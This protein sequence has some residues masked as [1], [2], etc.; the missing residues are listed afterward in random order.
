MTGDDR[1]RWALILGASSGMGEASS[2]ALAAAGYHICGVHLDLRSRRGHVD[3]V[4]SGIRALGREAIFLNLNAADDAQR[5]AAI[6]T[7]SRRFAE[8][9]DSGARPY[10]RVVLHSLAFGSLAPYLADDGQPA[11]DRRRMEM[12]ADVMAHSLVY[13][14]Q[15]L[16]AAGL[17]ESGS[18]IL[19]M[20]SEGSSIAVP[21]YGAVSAAKAALESHVRQL[22]LE[23]GRRGTGITV[24]AIQAGVTMTPALMKV[25]VHDE[26]IE[27]SRRRNPSGRMTTTSDVARA[28]VGL[29]G[30]AFGF[31][32][33]AVIPVDGGEAITR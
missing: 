30:D 3:E 2:L 31:V 6:E 32:N 1:T 5:I 21:T 14:A 12:T 10:L 13:W 8:I 16:F 25:P 19:A 26:I 4:T 11:I 15:G 29:A 27:M 18:R 24:N 33:G 7:L 23:F 20:T 17:L 28:V 9:R 22:A